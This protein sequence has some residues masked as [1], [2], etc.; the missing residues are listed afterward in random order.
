MSTTAT[1]DNAPVLDDGADRSGVG[2][3]PAREGPAAIERIEAGLREGLLILAGSRQKGETQG[4]G[5]RVK[6]GVLEDPMRIQLPI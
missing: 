2:A 4:A 3:S 5:A 6:A 1:D